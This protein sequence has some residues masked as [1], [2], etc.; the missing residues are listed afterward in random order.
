MYFWWGFIGC[1]TFQISKRHTLT[2]MVNLIVCGPKIN[3]I[4]AFYSGAGTSV[5]YYPWLP[6]ILG[7]GIPD[8][9]PD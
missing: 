2:N 3:K 7:P 5:S 9:G 4:Y 1:K 6:Q 8:Q